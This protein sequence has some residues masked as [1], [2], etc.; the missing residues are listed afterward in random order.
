MEPQEI[1]S[2][3]GRHAGPLA[4]TV[5]TEQIEKA[6]ELAT[7]VFGDAQ[8][9]KEWLNEPKLATDEKPPIALLGTEEGFARVMIFLHRIE[10]GI[11]A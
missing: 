7:S 11:L 6:M 1:D 3:S 10:W 2:N 5:L 9:A 4:S 8:F